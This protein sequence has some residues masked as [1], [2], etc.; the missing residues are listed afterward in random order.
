M[1]ATRVF[2]LIMNWEEIRL[3]WIWVAIRGNGPA[4]FTQDTGAAY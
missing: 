4:I 3:S 1:G 2:D